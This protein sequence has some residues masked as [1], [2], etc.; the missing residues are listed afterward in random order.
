MTIGWT[1]DKLD[2]ISDAQEM[3]I[4]GRRR[5]GSLRNP[6]S[7]G[8]V[9]IDV[10]FLDVDGDENAIND[11][12]DAAYRS[13]Y[14]LYPS[15]VAAIISPPARATTLKVVPHAGTPDLPQE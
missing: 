5:D 11:V 7:A 14:G 9:D 1:A 3:R 12:V 8:G 15:P 6:V 10:D 2:R 13:K 4:A